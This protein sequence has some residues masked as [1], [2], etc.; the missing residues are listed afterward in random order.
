MRQVGV[1]SHLYSM[2]I[3]NTIMFSLYLVFFVLFQCTEAVLTP[4]LLPQLRSLS[5][6]DLI[7]TYFHLNLSY[8]SILAFLSMCHGVFI[9]LSTLKRKL[10]QLGLYRRKWGVL[11]MQQAA[12]R[13]QV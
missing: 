6:D 13:I 5:L 9:S 11:D 1:P 8:S 7:V 2:A 4:P 3:E 10:R 12:A